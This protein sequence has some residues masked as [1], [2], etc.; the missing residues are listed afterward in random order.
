MPNEI[1]G[2][3]RITVGRNRAESQ[4]AFTH[5]LIVQLAALV[6]YLH[7][8]A[9]KRYLTEHLDPIVDQRIDIDVPVDLARTQTARELVLGPRRRHR[10]T[11]G[12]RL[13]YPTP[14]AALCQSDAEWDRTSP[15]GHRRAL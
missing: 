5:A 15:S 3:Q 12:G 2:V 8:P 11:T 7:H 6:N 1:D 9:R 14:L 4:H 13:S 10:R